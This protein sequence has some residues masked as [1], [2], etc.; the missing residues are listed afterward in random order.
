MIESVLCKPGSAPPGDKTSEQAR[1]Q[2]RYANDGIIDWADGFNWAS[3]NTIDDTSAGSRFVS[4]VVEL[5]EG[6][7]LNV[8]KIVLT[9]DDSDPS[10]FPPSTDLSYFTRPSD[11]HLRI[12]SKDAD[13]A[14]SAYS[15]LSGGDFVPAGVYTAQQL[16]FTTRVKTLYVEALNP[17]AI[18]A[19]QAVTVR[20]YPTGDLASPTVWV[21]DRV[22]ITSTRIEILADNH[23]GLPAY[24]TFGFSQTG[25]PKPASGSDEAQAYGA[26][27]TYVVN[28]YDP[29]AGFS[30]ITVD[31]TAIPIVRTASYYT[32]PNPFAVVDADDL[33]II[34][35]NQPVTGELEFE[36]SYRYPGIF[37]PDDILASPITWLVQQSGSPVVSVD[38]NSLQINTLAGNTTYSAKLSDARYWEPQKATDVEARFKLLGYDPQSSDGAFKLLLGDSAQHWEIGIRP[39]SLVLYPGGVRTVVPLPTSVGSAGNL[40]D[41]NFHTLRVSWDVGGAQATIRVDGVIVAVVASAAGA[42]FGIE[43]GDT[44]ADVGGNVLLDYVDWQHASLATE[45]EHIFT[46]LPSDVIGSAI[47]VPLSGDEVVIEYNPSGK[48]PSGAAKKLMQANQTFAE[49]IKKV[50]DEMD[51]EGWRPTNPADSGE[52]G[53]EV[54]RRASERI[55]AQRWGKANRW[56]TDVLVD[57]NTKQILSLNAPSGRNGATQ[58]DVIYFKGNYRPKVGDILDTNKTRIYEIKTSAGGTVKEAQRV[59][60]QSLQTDGTDIQVT[61]TR[62][63]YQQSTGSLVPNPKYLRSLQVLAAIGAGAISAYAIVHS[64]D[65]DPL[66]EEF[67]IELLATKAATNPND[68]LLHGAEAASLLKQYLDEVTGGFTD[69]GTSLILGHFVYHK[70]LPNLDNPGN[71]WQ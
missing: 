71:P 18:T 15:I 60:L 22:R 48:K 47:V 34:A 67:R 3:S 40:D 7:D 50:V 53:K 5:P 46:A 62:L 19:D 13:V 39:D 14:R 33:P 54:H 38:A 10:P 25:P 45:R 4:L 30:Q 17:S 61:G 52:F 42:R 24:E 51:A 20:V 21:E 31:G 58:V 66:L 29:R 37:L 64:A 32:T 41:G 56:K 16:G 65:S 49:I 12:W 27:Q 1:G 68:R 28:V 43:W 2:S 70:L 11:G 23:D 6:V 55:N 8:A 35:A 59:R 44:G 9:Y 36:S 69:V 57:D 63:K 26:W